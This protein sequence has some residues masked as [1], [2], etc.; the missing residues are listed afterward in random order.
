MNYNQYGKNGSN[1]EPKQGEN[2]P[3]P[4]PQLY[5]TPDY[6]RN[7]P[8]AKNPYTTHEFHKDLESIERLFRT[9]PMPLDSP[10]E[11]SSFLNERES[12]TSSL[13]VVG[14]FGQVISEF[15]N[16]VQQRAA[17]IGKLQEE[18]DEFKQSSYHNTQQSKNESL[19]E[20]FNF[21]P[22]EKNSFTNSQQT[23]K[24]ETN[25]NETLREPQKQNTKDLKKE[26]SAEKDVNSLKSNNDSTSTL[27]YRLSDQSGSPLN[28]TSETGSWSKRYESDNNN[29]ELK[30]FSFVASGEDTLPTYGSNSSHKKEANSSSSQK[31]EEKVYPS[32]ENDEEKETLDNVSVGEKNSDAERDD[33]FEQEQHS[34]QK[35]QDEY[36]TNTPTYENYNTSSLLES[37]QI[38][39]QYSPYNEQCKETNQVWQR[40]NEMLRMC[41]FS[42]LPNTKDLRQLSKSFETIVSGFLEEIRNKTKQLTN[43]VEQSKQTVDF[44]QNRINQL[45]VEV[46]QKD[47]ELEEKGDHCK[48]LKE[49]IFQYEQNSNQAQKQEQLVSKLNTKLLQYEDKFKKKDKYIESLLQKYKEHVE[50]EEKRMEHEKQLFKEIYGREP[51][52]ADNRVMKI[53]SMYENQ[54]SRL[55]QKVQELQRRLLETD[56][57]LQY[58]DNFLRYGSNSDDS[59]SDRFSDMIS[60]DIGYRKETFSLRSRVSE[61]EDQIK[62]LERENQRLS[63]GFRER[64]YQS[65]SKDSNSDY[66]YFVGNLSQLT[67]HEAKYILNDVM[68]ILNV[69]NIDNLRN[70]IAKFS[71]TLRAL[72][73]LQNCVSDIC[74]AVEKGEG[75]LNP[76]EKCVLEPTDV[77]NVINRWC[78][79]L[80]QM[81]QLETLEKKI[82]ERLVK[83]KDTGM[84]SAMPQPKKHQHMIEAIQILIETEAELSKSRTI[85]LAAQNSVQK[86]PQKLVNQII[87]YFQQLFDIKKLEGVVP[88]MNDIYR[89]LSEFQNVFTALKSMLDLS[90]NCSSNKLLSE[91]E[92]L[93]IQINYVK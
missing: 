37:Q 32:L 18:V 77:P 56:D 92:R 28:V 24:Y 63:E 85:L 57:M 61:L 66:D 30:S 51:R 9:P 53:I 78:Q 74:S 83:R 36:Q 62:Q 89:K 13:D 23:I 84:I 87:L 10:S 7:S 75:V 41:G 16:K 35:K 34:D 42:I 8:W 59:R 86:K 46:R 69:T 81:K 73:Q 33:H 52:I 48:E 6:L 47:Y 90:K 45:E 43:A 12:K 76:N 60:E 82:Q 1:S 29:Y 58:K 79:E 27:S 49:K 19:N 26:E 11:K 15:E 44:H 71:Q 4:S 20:N 38:K 21:D 88:K 31:R 2:Y 55:E 54:R 14:D 22:S 64:E 80:K 39:N 68:K 91:V 70:C 5:S 17:A 65:Y 3:N 67:N 72:P 50:K 40:I 25:E 93:T